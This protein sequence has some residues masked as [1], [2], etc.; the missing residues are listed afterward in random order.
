MILYYVAKA[1]KVSLNWMKALLRFVPFFI[2]LKLTVSTPSQGMCIKL[3]FFN[4]SLLS[5]H[6]PCIFFLVVLSL[7]YIAQFLSLAAFAL[8]HKHLFN[9][10]ISHP[11]LRILFGDYILI[12]FCFFTYCE[13]D[14]HYISTKLRYLLNCSR[15][16]LGFLHEIVTF[17]WHLEWSIIQYFQF[18]LR[19]FLIDI[20]RDEFWWKEE[21]QIPS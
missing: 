4:F 19:I 15:L 9:P 21:N 8:H 6:S 14:F 12:L 17:Q 5:F 13:K 7:W 11:Y 18:T 20:K 2:M 3:L 16:W 10:I 1:Q